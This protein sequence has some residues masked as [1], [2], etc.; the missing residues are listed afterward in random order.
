MGEVQANP[1]KQI[2]PPTIQVTKDYS[3]FKLMGGNRT[4]DYNHVK[5]LKQ[6]MRDN[7][8]LLAGNPIIVNENMFIIDGQHRRQ[9]AQELA[10]PMYYIVLPGATL[11]ETRHLNV[12]QRRWN[13]I[14]FAKSYADSG[15]QDYK[16]FLEFHKKYPRISPSIVRIYLVGTETSDMEG[17]FRRG[18][19]QVGEL[20]SAKTNLDFLTAVVE[21]THVT[22]NTPMARAI[23]KLLKNKEFDRVLFLE[24]LDREGARELFQTA[25]AIRGC[26]RSIENVY[27]FGS[28][29]QKRLY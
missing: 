6:E 12:T 26:L 15:H 24:K 8:H 14:D 16:Q 18:K 2:T 5:Q 19:Y 20:E 1:S 13:M 9:A 3:K 11:D 25:S 17:D 21:K 10:V 7:P 22:I 23:L 29:W 28:R 27:N 4:V